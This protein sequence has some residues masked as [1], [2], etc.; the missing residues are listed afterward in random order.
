[1]V[2][3]LHLGMRLEHKPAEP[4]AFLEPDYHPL[5]DWPILGSFVRPSVDAGT[6]LTVVLATGGVALAVF[7]IRLHGEPQ[8]ADRKADNLLRVPLPVKAL[9]N[10]AATHEGV[11]EQGARSPTKRAKGHPEEEEPRL[12]EV[13]GSLLTVAVPNVIAYVL[14]SVQEIINTAFVGRA[15]SEAQLAAVGLGNMMKNC[16]A[17]T[18]CWGICGAMDALVSQAYGAGQ[19]DRCC[20]HLQR[21]RI[22]VTMQLVW[23]VPVLWYSE[24]LLLAIRQDPEVAHHAALYIRATI[25]GLFAFFQFEATRKFLINRNSPTAAAVIAGA[26]SAAHIGWCTLFVLHLHLGIAGA[27]YANVVTWW[28]QFLISSAY[29]YFAAP[30]MGLRRQDVLWFGREGWSKWWTYAKIAGPATFQICADFWFDQIASVEAGYLGALALAAHVPAYSTYNTALMP[31]FGLQMSTA[32]LVGQKL[33][34]G[35]PRGARLAAHVSLAVAGVT[36]LLLAAA[37]VGWRTQVG[38]A[39]TDDV[40]VQVVVSRLLCFYAASGF[41]DS[42]QIVMGGVL[43]GLGR[44]ETGALI[45]MVA[46][47]AVGLPVG[48]VL[49]FSLGQGIDGL[50]RSFLAANATAVLLCTVTLSRV[51][52]RALEDDWDGGADDTD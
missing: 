6:T 27:G 29:L 25:P 9:L 44:Q 8:L 19:H 38:A 50:V 34:A 33:G 41:L 42:A 21:A 46:Y 3:L 22:L 2:A 52:W 47:Y 12:G 20:H 16:V 15:G 30:G 23:M 24:E 7:L 10:K 39:Y 32:T 11:M 26:C 14:A 40:G 18:V 35:Q 17:I 13:L 36:W 1:M 43:R 31:A 51:P 28:S 48:L 4:S 5:Q 49:A 45:S 37:M